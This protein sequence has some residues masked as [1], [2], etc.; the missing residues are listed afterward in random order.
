MALQLKFDSNLDFQLE[1][2][3]SIVDLFDGLPRRATEFSLSS[4]AIPNFNSGESFS[5]DWLHTNLREVQDRNDP[6]GILIPRSLLG[7]DY[8]DGLELEGVG[9]DSWRY[10]SYTIE[11]ET[12]T[13]KTY[14]YLRTI[15]ELRKKYGFGKFIVVV[16]SIAIYEGV[17]KNFDITQNHLKSLYDNE[18]VNLTPYD[19]GQIS[20]LRSFATST[21][22]E[23]MVITIDAFN[24][25]SNNIYKPS[26]KLPGEKKPFE[27]IQDTCPILI[28]DE[29]QNMASDRAKMALRTLHPLF[30]L[31]FSATHKESPNT[32]YRLTPFEAFRRR[33]VK[34]ISVWGVTESENMNQPFLAL[35]S[36]SKQPPWT[37]KV[38]A[39]VNDKGKLRQETITLKQGNDLNKQ[40]HCKEHE[41]GYKVVNI[42]AGEKYLEF[43]NGI[44]LHLNETIGPSRP[45]I[46]RE[47][48][49]QTIQRHMTIQEELWDEGIKVLSLFFI[50]RVA[51]F[52]DANGIIRVIFDEEF[53]RLRE[54]YPHFKAREP[55]D[56]RRHYFAKKKTAAGEQEIDTHLDEDEKTQVDKEAEKA[57][58]KL[59]MRDKEQLLSLDE[60]VGFIFAHSA[61][62]EGWDNPNVFQICTLNQTVSEMK[63][64][65]EIGRGLRLPVDQNGERIHDDDINVLTVIANQ[66]Y[67]SYAKNL[68]NEYYEVGDA[69]APPVGNARATNVVRNDNVFNSKEF[70]QFWEKLLLGTRYQ[71]NLLTDDL[72]GQCVTRLNKTDYPTPVIV[73]EKSDFIQIEYTIALEKIYH[74]TAHI[75]V[76]RRRSDGGFLSQ[77]YPLQKSNDLAKIVDDE[78]LR[79][80]KIAEI[81]PSSDT[82]TFGNGVDLTVSLPPQLPKA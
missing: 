63:K 20:R 55:Q 31:R 44:K 3:R 16:P 19:S 48:I 37:A 14:V 1:A 72:I 6:Q 82:V 8:D 21:F 5:P 12:G 35:E 65:Q 24:K 56:V 80:F 9:D 36:I 32:I 29:P 47:Q 17:I 76:E 27:Y 58:F 75:S 10:P 77:S 39:Y 7:V 57:A 11:M 18:V 38:S 59:I 13:G 61:L 50:D 51:N 15:Y 34:K 60:P 64:R 52:I 45:A 53:K 4:E 69:I 62:K 68:Q 54:E 74:Q 71:I 79:G 70:N 78:N 28:L 26:E 30:A 25:A 22:T 40:T 42:H 66:S 49:R 67:E 2:I 81:D 33:L 43:D 46:F 23:V 73:V 41:G